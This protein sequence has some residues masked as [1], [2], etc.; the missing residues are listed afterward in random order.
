MKYLTLPKSCPYMPKSKKSWESWD[1]ILPP[2]HIVWQGTSNS[3]QKHHFHAVGIYL[4]D[5]IIPNNEEGNFFTGRHII[6]TMNSCDCG[7]LYDNLGHGIYY[8]AKVESPPHTH[9]HTHHP[10]YH[11]EFSTWIRQLST[12][13]G[14]TSTVF[15]IFDRTLTVEKCWGCRKN[16]EVTSGGG[17]LD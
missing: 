4:W 11:P 6:G 9:T 16:V 13:F 7:E 17:G 12:F 2:G 1:H 8:V 15:H 3:F 14:T 5:G 10:P